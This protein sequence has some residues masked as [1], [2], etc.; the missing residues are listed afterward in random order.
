[1][2][3]SNHWCNLDINI[4]TNKHKDLNFV[5]ANHGEEEEINPLTTIEIAEAQCKDQE[6]KVYLKK[7][8]KTPKEDVRFQLI[9]DTTVLCKND[10]Q[11][12]P[13]SLRHRAVSWYHHYFQHPGHLHLKETMRSMIYWK[14]MRNTIQ[15]YN[16]SGRSCQINTRHSQKYGHVPPKRVITT[17]WKA[18]CV[19]LI[20]PNTLKGKDNSSVDFMCLTMINPSTSWFKIEELPT[21]TKEMTAPTMDKGKKVTFAEK[22]KVTEIT[23]D[24][25]SAQISNLVYM[26]WFSRY[27]H[28]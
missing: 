6:L 12:I 11:I 7:N 23:F 14:G 8:A 17:P 16:K 28:C 9:E 13:A 18:L 15:K 4:N 24:K 5:F 20:G 10:K 3:V 19:D 21:V 22:T 26:T 27:P 25:S 1:M 2:A